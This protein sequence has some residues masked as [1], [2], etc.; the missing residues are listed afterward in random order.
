MGGK[1]GRPMFTHE[2]KEALKKFSGSTIQVLRATFKDL[3]QR[4]GSGNQSLNKETFLKYFP[5]PGMLGERLYAVF[6]KDKNGSIDFQEFITG[7]ALIYH[8][9]LEEKQKFLFEMYDFDG[10]GVVTKTEL[11]TMLNHIPSAFK[12]LDVTLQ[13]SG[14]GSY[15]RHQRR[16]SD[17]S[18]VA[19][20][21]KVTSIVEAAFANKG[22]NDVLTYEEFLQTMNKLPEVAEIMTVL[23]EEKLPEPITV[24]RQNSERRGR[25]LHVDVTPNGLLPTPGSASNRTSRSPRPSSSSS[26]PRHCP[27][28]QAPTVFHFCFRCG[29]PLDSHNRNCNGCRILYSDVAF[30]GNCGQALR[31]AERKNSNLDTATLTAKAAQAAQLLGYSPARNSSVGSSSSGSPTN[32]QVPPFSL[33]AIQSMN[34]MEIV[35]PQVKVEESGWLGKFGRSLK[36]YKERW[37]FLKDKFMYSYRRP[38]DSAPSSVIFLEGCFVEEDAED[39]PKPNRYGFAITSATHKRVLYAKTEAEREKWIQALRRATRDVPLHEYYELKEELG[40]GKF[41]IVRLAVHKRTHQRF[42]VKIIS[43]KNMQESEREFIRT[44]VAILK[45]VRHPN[46]VKLMDIFENA[47]Y[48]YLVMELMDGGDLLERVRQ[49]KH[50]SE[51]DAA[52]VV[53]SIASALLYLHSYGITHRDLKP[54]NIMMVT[55][56]DQDLVKVTDFGLSKLVGPDERLSEPLGTLAYVAPE[57]LRH[58]PYDKSAD[59]WSVGVIGY[60]ILR[61]KLPFD[62]ESDREIARQTVEDS[63]DFND[64]FWETVSGAAKDLINGLLQK[65]PQRRYTVQ[66]VLNHPWTEKAAQRYQEQHQSRLKTRPVNA[67]ASTV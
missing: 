22:P 20:Q 16:E 4:S 46:I 11:R 15:T 57:I 14:E 52:Y 41:G 1:V 59:L 47:D 3:S 65:E 42:A 51:Q 67:V 43:K 28:C 33:G 17:S 55:A 13:E 32:Q 31:R 18:E 19:T 25:T 36:Q 60:L 56:T 27:M 37:F 6:D 26:E 44:E 23:W 9:T 8:G 48:L 49:V 34:S 35:D 58:H 21:A 39:E 12:I 24:N 10:D 5:L 53:Y 66:Q 40:R 61:G 62:S 63:L 50:F 30:C 7:L 54:E 2:Y 64:P 29:S 38:S 45:L